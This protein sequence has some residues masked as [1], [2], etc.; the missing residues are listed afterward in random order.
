MTQR[1][2]SVREWLTRRPELGQ[3]DN[4]LT[5]LHKEDQ[6]GYK[7]YLGITSDLFQEMSWDG[8]HCH[9]QELIIPPCHNEFMNSWQIVHDPVA[10]FWRDQNSEHFK[11][12]VPTLHTVT[13]GLRTLHAS[14]QLVCAIVQ[15]SRQFSDSVTDIYTY[16]HMKWIIKLD[17]DNLINFMLIQIKHYFSAV[18]KSKNLSSRARGNPFHMENIHHRIHNVSHQFSSDFII[19]SDQI[20]FSKNNIEFSLSS[21]FST[22]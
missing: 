6:R 16:K 9:T 17:D 7:N 8:V 14:L 11:I 1:K 18:R 20:Y 15:V 2:A 10:K 21:G 13:T 22:T 3:Y 4:L 5:E 19:L 12:I